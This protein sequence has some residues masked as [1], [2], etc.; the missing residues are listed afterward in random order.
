MGYWARMEARS[1]PLH[2]KRLDKHSCEVCPIFC[3]RLNLSN[4]WL[5]DR[6]AVGGMVG[7]FILMRLLIV[8]NFAETA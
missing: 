3:L 5:V 1:P 2:C 4:I 6:A 8:K 7:E